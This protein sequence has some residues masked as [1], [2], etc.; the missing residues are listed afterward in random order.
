[1]KSKTW[2]VRHHVLVVAAASALIGA[3]C[4]AA[5][6]YAA[7]PHMQNALGALQ[8]ARN[9]LQV[10]EH[11]KG[12]HRVNALRFVDSAINEVRAGLAAGS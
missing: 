2:L 5:V 9:E 4:A 12:G 6:S 10:A 8:S 1:M 7:Q 3:G 11:D